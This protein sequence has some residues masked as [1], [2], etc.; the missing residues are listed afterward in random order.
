M[1]CIITLHSNCQE[2]GSAFHTGFLVNHNNNMKIFNEKIPYIYQ[3]HIAKTTNGKK[4]WHSFYGYPRY[5]VSYMMLDLGSPS[6]LK[7]AHGIYPFMNFFLTNA[8]RKVS[9]NTQ[10][11]GG[12][13][14]M[15]KIFNRLDNYKNMAISSRFNAVL[16]LKMEGRARVAAP[17]YLSGGWAFTH[18]SNGTVKN[19]MRD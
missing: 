19:P 13:A 14:Y 11:G 8:D 7:K 2:I 3:L 17:L 10:L 6:H 18:L 16:S 1:F 4:A 12:I 15:E 9:L 5:G